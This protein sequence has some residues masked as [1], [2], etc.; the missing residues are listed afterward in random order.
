MILSGSAVRTENVHLLARMLDGDELA[1][2]LERAVTN[3]NSIVALTVDDRH[4][5]VAVLAGDAPSG[6]TELRGILIKQLKQHDDRQKQEQRVRLHQ[7]R[8]RRQ[9]E[10]LR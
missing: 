6:L 4:R 8:A 9:H 5:I 10:D 1:A 7:E 3:G 2:T